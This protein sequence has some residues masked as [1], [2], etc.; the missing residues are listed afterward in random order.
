MFSGRCV[1]SGKERSPTFAKNFYTLGSKVK[2]TNTPKIIFIEKLFLLIN[3]FGSKLP[4]LYS[5]N[6][7]HYKYTNK[8]VLIFE[9]ISDQNKF[10]SNMAPQLSHLPP[11]SFNY[12]DMRPR[13]T[14]HFVAIIPRR[15][16]ATIETSPSAFDSEPIHRN[17][18]SSE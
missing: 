13:M 7:H 2:R 6:L 9:D 17:S 16:R 5:C 12:N 18:H 11:N 10:P 8:F 4:D 3:D 1:V 14:R 15:R